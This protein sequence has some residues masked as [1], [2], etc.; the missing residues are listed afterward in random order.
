MKVKLSHIDATLD[1]GRFLGRSLL[2]LLIAVIVFYLLL[3]A[4][5]MTVIIVGGKADAAEI[6]GISI[7]ILCGGA[8]FICP[9]AWYLIRNERLKRVIEKCIADSDAAVLAA[10]AKDYDVSGSARA[11]QGS[12][13][14][15]N[16]EYNGEKYTRSSGQYGKTMLKNGYDKVFNNY[17]N[18]EILILYSPK[19]NQIL[20]IKEQFYYLYK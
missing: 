17:V 8:I 2:G 19:Y 3:A 12:K 18:K 5:V 13:I 9:C 14:T 11:T 1:R 20:L 10:S 15:V 6:L 7:E 4:I 16:F